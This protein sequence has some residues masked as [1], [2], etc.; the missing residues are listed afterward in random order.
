MVR[1]QWSQWHDGASPLQRAVSLHG[2]F[3]TL[4]HGRG[5]PAALRRGQVQRVLGRIDAVGR[6][7]SRIARA[8]A[9][10]SSVAGKDAGWQQVEAIYDATR[11]KVE[12][13]AG[14]LKGAARALADAVVALSEDGDPEGAVRLG[15]AAVEGAT[16]ARQGDQQGE[17]QDYT[18]TA[19]SSLLLWTPLPFHVP[20]TPQGLGVVL[21]VHE[22]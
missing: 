3:R 8:A 22:L 17:E 20:R 7:A 19:A 14:E 16:R 12:Y 13:K 1:E 2:K 9:R 15:L 21:V 11:E 10:L 18:R 6:C 5:D 4:G